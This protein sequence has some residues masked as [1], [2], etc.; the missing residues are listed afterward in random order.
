MSRITRSSRIDRIIVGAGLAFA[1][2]FA[3][4]CGTDDPQVPTTFTPPAGA[5]L[6][7]TGTVATVVTP[8]PKVQILDAAGKGIKGIV[9]HWKVGTGSGGVASDS[10]TTDGSGV[11][12]S[13]NWTLGA[14]AG[15]QTLTATANG[16]SPVT[17]TAQATAGPATSLIRLGPSSQQATVGTPV[18]PDVRLRDAPHRALVERVVETLRAGLGLGIGHRR[19]IIVD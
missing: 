7:L 14:I 15:P 3:T 10:S 13:G 4:A 5:T 8:A 17:F 2:L 6:A 19:H 1:T 11:A 12:S 18:D 9:V 16:V